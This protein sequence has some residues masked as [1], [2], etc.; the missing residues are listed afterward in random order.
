[1]NAALTYI[2]HFKILPCRVR[3]SLI[4]VKERSVSDMAEAFGL[5]LFKKG[6]QM[7]LYRM[8]CCHE[9]KRA[10]AM[11]YFIAHKILDYVSKLIII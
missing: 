2:I 8:L 4:W 6:M 1:M 9:N 11:V 5:Y 3:I 10:R 7:D